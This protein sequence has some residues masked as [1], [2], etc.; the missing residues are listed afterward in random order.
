MHGCQISHLIEQGLATGAKLYALPTVAKDL[1]WD[2]AN[3]L[4]IAANDAPEPAA[5]RRLARQA[6]ELYGQLPNAERLPQ[7]HDRR[8]L[9]R[10]LSGR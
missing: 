9:A 10:R 7:W 4:V 1:R 2:Y 3:L 5:R 6:A 8:E